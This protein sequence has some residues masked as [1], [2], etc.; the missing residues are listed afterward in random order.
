[1]AIDIIFGIISMILVCLKM[2]LYVSLA[3]LLCVFC[4]ITEISLCS[5]F[6]LLTWKLHISALES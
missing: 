6:P 4:W 2:L 3:F 5:V 1:M